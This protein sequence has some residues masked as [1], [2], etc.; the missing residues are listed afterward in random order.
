M[1][2]A[3]KNHVPGSVLTNAF[4]T[5]Y[6]APA[7]T[8]ARINNATVTNFDAVARTVTVAIVASGGAAGTNNQCILVKSLQPNETYNCPELVGKNVMPGGTIQALASANTAVNLMVSGLEQ[9]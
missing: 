7:A 5:Y 4:A 9:S 2:V 3:L 8:T 6:T 1:T